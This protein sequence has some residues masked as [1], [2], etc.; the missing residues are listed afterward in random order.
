M[1]CCLSN[2]TNHVVKTLQAFLA[3]L[4]NKLSVIILCFGIWPYSVLAILEGGVYTIIA[5]MSSEHL[6]LLTRREFVFPRSE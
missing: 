6:V 1:S 5:F 2:S 3:P 4:Q